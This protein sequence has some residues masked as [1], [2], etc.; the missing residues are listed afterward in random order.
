MAD[1]RRSKNSDPHPCH[2]F[3]LASEP[4]SGCHERIRPVTHQLLRNGRQ[5]SV[6]LSI[7]SSSQRW[8]PL[9]DWAARWVTS[10]CAHCCSDL[11]KIHLCPFMTKPPHQ[12]GR[13]LVAVL[14][15]KQ[16]IAAIPPF[17]QRLGAVLTTHAQNS[18][19]TISTIT[20]DTRRATSRTA[21]PA[22]RS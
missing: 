22:P 7:N 2:R 1:I 5:R 17:C 10:R 16:I 20:I 13:G 8:Y 12:G 11:L 9:S 15:V 6:E 21:H 19:N 3:T 18:R 14:R 4:F